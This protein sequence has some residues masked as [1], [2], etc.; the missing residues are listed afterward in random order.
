MKIVEKIK[1]HWDLIMLALFLIGTLMI[2]I[3]MSYTLNQLFTQIEQEGLKNILQPL[4][5]G[6]G[7]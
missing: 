4:W 3:I 6:T 1:E 2:I 7:K 5:E